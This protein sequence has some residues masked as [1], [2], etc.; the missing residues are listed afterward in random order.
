MAS[1]LCGIDSTT[2]TVETGSVCCRA[3]RINRASNNTCSVEVAVGRL[4]GSCHG[5]LADRTC[6]VRF[7]RHEARGIKVDTLNDVKFTIRGG[8][9][10]F[11][12]IGRPASALSTGH[13][14]EVKDKEA[15]IV[16]LLAL[17]SDAVTSTSCGNIGIVDS[18]VDAAVVVCSQ[19]ASVDRICLTEV[20]HVSIGRIIALLLNKLTFGSV[21]LGILTVKKSKLSAN[22]PEV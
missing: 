20:V 3:G 16:D 7:H 18:H 4:Q 10:A 17:D 14:R 1:P 5:L 15:M 22:T 21:N 6:L 19:Q 13:M 11:Q 12:P 9:G 2:D 8:L